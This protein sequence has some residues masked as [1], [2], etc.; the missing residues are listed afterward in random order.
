M[1]RTAGAIALQVRQP[2]TFRHHTLAG[3]GGVAVHQER[4]HRNALVGR[5][6]VLVLLGAHLAEHNRIDDFQM[7]RV[8]GQRQMDLVVV[9]LAIRRRAQM[10]FDVAGAFDRVGIGGAALELMEQ[11]AMRLAHHLGQHVE[12]ATMRHADD[13]FLHAEIAAALDDLFQRRNQRL[14]AIKAEALGAGEF[15]IA[16]FLKALGFDELVENRAPPLAGEADFL[17]RPLDAFLDPGLLRSV[18]DVHEFDAERLAVSALADRDDFAKRAIFEAKHMIEKDFSVEIGLS[19]TVRARIEFFTIAWRLDA[20]RV[21]LGVKMAAHAIGP[22]QHQGAHRV[23]GGL[24]DIGRRQF[25]APGLRLGRKLGADRLFDLDPVTVE[26]GSEF[27]ARRQRPVV[28]G[29]RGSFGA[30]PD[31]GRRIF[32]ALEELLPLGVDRGGIVLV[33]GVDFID[34]GGVCALQKRGEGKGGVRILAR[35]GGVLVIFGSRVEYGAAAGPA[36]GPAG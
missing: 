19:K 6:A 16:E 31:V 35:H 9:V 2:E 7:R 30:F 21:E 28:A 23:A 26:R 20:E 22:D 8:G 27:V 29:P 11:R 32:Q 1:Q 13:D 36:T 17:V 33:T 12:P 15:D 10:I 24:M 5:I 3:E 34:I 18:G 4:Q 25:C 14:A